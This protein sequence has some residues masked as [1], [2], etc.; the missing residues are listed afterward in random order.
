M[1]KLFMFWLSYE[2][3]IQEKTNP[4]FS[5]VRQKLSIYQLKINYNLKHV[6]NE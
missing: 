5:F 6:E 4:V 2:R 3:G 1:S